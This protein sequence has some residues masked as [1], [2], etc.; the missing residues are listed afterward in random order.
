MESLHKHAVAEP[1]ETI[2][3]SVSKKKWVL[4]DRAAASDESDAN[5]DTSAD[6]NQEGGE[7]K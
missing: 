1:E 3:Q 4:V 2:A 5:Q 7:T 6:E